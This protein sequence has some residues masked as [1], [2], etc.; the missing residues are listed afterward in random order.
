MSDQGFDSVQN[1]PE[2]EIY[3][4]SLI[5]SFIQGASQQLVDA[6]IIERDGGISDINSVKVGNNPK[7]LQFLQEEHPTLLFTPNSVFEGVLYTP[8]E[9]ATQFGTDVVELFA[10]TLYRNGVSI[11]E[12]HERLNQIISNKFP[13][14][15]QGYFE[16]ILSNYDPKWL[17]KIVIGEGTF[18]DNIIISQLNQA[19]TL[20]AIFADHPYK[21]YTGHEE[22]F[23][24]IDAADVSEFIERKQFSLE[25]LVQAKLS[26][27]P[28]Q[29]NKLIYSLQVPAHNEMPET[30]EEK[31]LRGNLADYLMSVFVGIEK[32]RID[33]S[34]VEVLINVNNKKTE[35]GNVH[36]IDYPYATKGNL[37]TMQL[38]N[39][40][41]KSVNQDI[42]P[43]SI[44][45]EIDS[46][47]WIPEITEKTD[48]HEQKRINALKTFYLRLYRRASH[49]YGLGLSVHKIDC[50]DG[51][52]IAR[53]GDSQS[54]HPVNGQGSR[55]RLLEEIAIRRFKLAREQ[56]PSLNEGMQWHLPNDADAKISPHMFLNIQSATQNNQES[57]IIVAPMRI[58]EDVNSPQKDTK[59]THI[60]ISRGAYGLRDLINTIKE[61]GITNQSERFPRL[62][63]SVTRFA[64]NEKAVS[65]GSVLW[66]I[67]KDMGEDDD[68]M[69]KAIQN[70]SFTL[71]SEPISTVSDRIRNNSYGGRS[72]SAEDLTTNY[73]GRI[74]RVSKELR[75]AILRTIK[76]AN[77]DLEINP[78]SMDL[79]EFSNF[80]LGA[81]HSKAHTEAELELV[82]CIE[83]DPDKY[84]R[85]IKNYAESEYAQYIWNA[86][87][88]ISQLLYLPP[89]N[90]PNLNDLLTIFS[91]NIHEV[92]V[93]HNATMIYIT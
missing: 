18:Q 4:P 78:K 19:I 43:E 41:E 21:D 71:M 5:R 38:L 6:H 49:L 60:E 28:E 3:R 10:K 79:R 8:D 33:P 46:F 56:N 1:I 62:V 54:S 22:L 69:R 82:E 80:I 93:Q 30:G 9:D 34:E 12:I 29:S 81:L 88:G 89:E 87:R 11:E 26:K 91:S 35:Y 76:D 40:L 17:Q 63:P 68:F 31:N 64:I 32:S 14:E 84:P 66:D 59:Y 65:S 42:Q 74:P 67:K 85:T 83:K 70:S 92:E 73:F 20:S 16:K 36:S 51:S 58:A 23:D 55:R 37:H 50:T 7:L 39:F 75:T 45:K 52:F 48:P 90:Y 25:E 57:Q 77:L 61:F 15:I 86:W 24:F 13:S 72:S 2:V 27:M 53:D 44:E 47:S